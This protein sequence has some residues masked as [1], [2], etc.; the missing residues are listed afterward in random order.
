VQARPGNIPNELT[1][2]ISG[3]QIGDAVRVRDL[4][5][6]AG[7]TTDLDP[8]EPVIIASGSPLSADEAEL[9][10]SDEAAAEAAASGAGDAAGGGSGDAGS[11][12]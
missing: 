2:D 12:G 3:L 8:E 10:A 6:P 11:E 4:P 7:V 5:L 1:I 9:E